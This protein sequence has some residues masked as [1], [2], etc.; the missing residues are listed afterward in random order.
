MKQIYEFIPGTVDYC[1]FIY[2]N[3]FLKVIIIIFT[4]LVPILLIIIN[5]YWID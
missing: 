2:Y 5:E 3:L 1:A 4:E